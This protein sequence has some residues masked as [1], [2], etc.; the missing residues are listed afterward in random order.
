V[1]PSQVHGAP[2]ELSI[3]ATEGYWTGDELDVVRYSMRVDGF[4][5]LHAPRSGGEAVTQPIR[6]SGERLVLNLATSAAGH[7]RVEVQNPAG[8]PVEG[9]TLD[10]SDPLFGDD[11]ARVATWRR[12]DA[13]LS[14]LP[15]RPVRLRFSI[16]DADVYSLRF[17]V[18][19]TFDS[20]TLVEQYH[21]AAVLTTE[22]RRAMLAEL[23]AA[24]TAAA[25][26]RADEA[27]AALDRFLTAASAVSDDDARDRLRDAG[28]DLARQVTDPWP[29]I[30]GWLGNDVDPATGN[31]ENLG[32]SSALVA[33]DYRNRSVG[34]AFWE[35][36]T[37]TKL[38]LRDVDG[39]TRL[40]PGDL[41]V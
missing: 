9:F 13:D 7:V 2:D 41:T 3:Y 24:Q 18:A 27:G 20:R 21:D 16:N 36:V 40:H 35:P 23:T 31:L 19:I 28:K 22:Q 37:I 26:G 15:G 5:S 29:T 14:A 34:A 6:I 11:L 4:I 38:T 12:G 32:L 8:R 1:T 30:Y 10:D 17:R 33:L 25:E 39:T